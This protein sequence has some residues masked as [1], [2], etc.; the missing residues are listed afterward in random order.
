MKKIYQKIRRRI[1]YHFYLFNFFFTGDRVFKKVKKIRLNE[2][3]S[4][5]LELLYEKEKNNPIVLHEYARDRIENS[6]Y[7]GFKII[8]NFESIREKWLKKNQALLN[9]QVFIPIQQFIGSLGNYFTLYYYIINHFY[10]EKKKTK[11]SVLLKETEKIT[12]PEIYKFFLPF[13][14]VIQNNSKFYKYN[15]SYEMHKVPMEIVLP[16]KNL[17]FPWPVAINFINQDLKKKNISNITNFVMSEDKII[18]GKKKLSKFG[19]SDKD[20]FV[21]LHVRQGKGHNF[22]N[23]NPDTYIMAIQDIVSRGGY[24]IRVGDASLSKLPKIPG[25]IDYPFT[26]LKSDFM[27]VFLAS[28]CKFCIG[29]ASGY[30]G[31]SPFFGKPL[32]L[33]NFLPTFEYFCYK[34]TDIFL[35]K[36]LIDKKNNELVPLEKLFNFEI[37]NYV[38]DNI[39]EEKKI[40]IQDNTP[41]EIL[42]ATQEM[43]NLVDKKDQNNFFKDYN[44]RFKKELNSLYKNYFDYHLESSANLPSYFLKKYYF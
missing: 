19:I 7:N 39:Y 38:D 32:L 29:T 27:D 30:A 37:G 43:F 8:K 4:E 13:L 25:L 3:K 6:D 26:E 15:Y 17:Y 21:V 41:E 1:Q 28:A 16:Y 22:R 44:T 34:D 20:W 2:K 24:V 9:S 14:N 33:V 40:K 42:L 11:L 5:K 12:N 31:L 18:E 10:L 35:P 36:T 23:S